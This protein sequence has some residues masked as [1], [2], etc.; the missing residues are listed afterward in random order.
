LLRKP[1]VGF[2]AF[3]FDLIP[4]GNKNQTS[5]EMKRRVLGLVAYLR[6]PIESIFLPTGSS[7]GGA[8]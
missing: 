7:F 4:K 8:K 6:P 2:A 5:S 3:L 1:R